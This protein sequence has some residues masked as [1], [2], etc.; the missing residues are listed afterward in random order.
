MAKGHKK[1]TLFGKPQGEVIKKPGSETKRAQEHGRSLHEQAEIDEH[2]PNK[3]IR[4]KGIFALNAQEHKI[5]KKPHHGK[6]KVK[7]TAKKRVARKR[8]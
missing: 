4:G 1:G 7:K 5:G 8:A 6:T 2:S 3:R